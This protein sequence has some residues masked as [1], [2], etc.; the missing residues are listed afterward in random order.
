MKIVI[1][2][3]SL[4]HGGAERVI[5]ILANKLI[6]LGHDVELLLYYDYP[7]W[8]PLDERIHITIDEKQIGKANIFRHMAYRRRCL[9]KINPDV[10]VSFLAPFNM[11][12]IV[13]MVGLRI[14]LVVADRNDPAQIPANK[15]LR[16][17]RNALYKLATGVVVQ[18]ETNKEYFSKDIQKKCRVIYNPINISEYLGAALKEKKGKVIVSTGRLIQ[19][20]NQKLLIDAF[21]EIAKKY[22]EYKLVIYGEGL[23]RKELEQYIVNKGL[24]SRVLLPGSVK[25]IFDEIKTAEVFVLSSNYEGMPNAL[26]EA[27]CLGLPVISTN[28]SGSRDLIVNGENGILVDINDK[29]A[30]VHAIETIIQ[31]PDKAKNMGQKALEIANVLNTDKIVNQWI[32]Y[33]T[34]VI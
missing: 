1:S 19:Q 2:N 31:S 22:S 7:I 20:K 30:M 8:Y 32:D 25:N 23:Y 12:T 16:I 26:L 10:V 4:S 11:V 9:K 14:P 27:M 5:S 33:I 18:T 28:V 17:C 13:G 15:F 29:D 21:S 34:K 24:T 3:A 6:E